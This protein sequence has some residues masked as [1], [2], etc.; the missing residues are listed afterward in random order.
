MA[1]TFVIK[2]NNESAISFINAFTS[3][4]ST[5]ISLVIGNN[6]PV[7]SGI[8]ISLAINEYTSCIGVPSL[9]I[10]CPYS[11]NLTSE[12]FFTWCSPLGFP[13]IIIKLSGGTSFL[14]FS[15]KNVRSALI[16]SGRYIICNFLLELELS[17]FHILS[18]SSICACFTSSNVDPLRLSVNK[19][20]NAR[21]YLSWL[22]IS[23]FSPV[24][25]SVAPTSFHIVLITLLR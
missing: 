19:V 14:I 2:S 22:T 17:V 12:S 5:F 25:L 23:S 6:V 24:N 10:V 15:S 20:S 4:T 3:I 7:G 9:F 8:S 16:W 1:S 13:Y 18:F 11:R 21:V